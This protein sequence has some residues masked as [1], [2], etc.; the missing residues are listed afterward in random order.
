MDTL[1][2]LKPEGSNL[3]THPIL[4]SQEPQ[5]LRG[6]GLHA[7]QLSVGMGH[8][9][10]LWLMPVR[11]EQLSHP[12][13]FH[14]P[15]ALTSIEPPTEV[16]ARTGLLP[17]YANSQCPRGNLHGQRPKHDQPY[18]PAERYSY[19]EVAQSA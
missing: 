6:R 1:S 13:A 8:G 7:L 16:Q 14:M 9:V 17:V 19:L 12:E 11:A 3:P 5:T 2:S 4:N 10:S 15:V 18:P